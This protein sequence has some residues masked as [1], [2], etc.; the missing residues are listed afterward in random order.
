MDLI[1]LEFLK[2]RVNVAIVVFLVWVF[3]GDHKPKNKE[4]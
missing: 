1:T 3:I 2:E 4:K